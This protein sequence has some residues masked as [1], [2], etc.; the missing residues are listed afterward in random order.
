MSTTIIETTMELDDI[1]MTNYDAARLTFETTDYHGSD[2]VVINLELS[3]MI[4]IHEA[5]GKMIVKLEYNN[6]DE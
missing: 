4:E 2:R 5:L 3:D 1:M 6:E